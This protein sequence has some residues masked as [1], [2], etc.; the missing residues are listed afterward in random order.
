MSKDHTGNLTL[1]IL[2]GI[3]AA[4]NDNVATALFVLLATLP[5][6]AL[7]SALGIAVI[8]A[9]FVTSSDS[10]S[11]VVDIITAGGRTDPP[12]VQRV[13][14]AV[15]EG[16]VAAVLLIGGGL[17]ALQTGVIITGLPFALVLLL[18]GYSLLRGLREDGASP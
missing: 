5:W 7:T 15:T 2:G 12:T 9:F 3:V 11:L 17:G 18:L 1:Y 13:F 6:S 14:W 4:V 8:I 10:A 16:V